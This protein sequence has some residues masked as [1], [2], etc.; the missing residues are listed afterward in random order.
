MTVWDSSPTHR[1]DI[2][3]ALP[4]HLGK[5]LESQTRSLEGGHVGMVELRVRNREFIMIVGIDDDVVARIGDRQLLPNDLS[6]QILRKTV[7]GKPAEQFAY[8]FLKEACTRTSPAWGAIYRQ[9][10]YDF[11]VMQQ[12]PSV[13]AIGRDFGRFL[14][15]LFAVNYFGERY[16]TLFGDRRIAQLKPQVVEPAGS[17]VVVSVASPGNWQAAES[18]YAEVLDTLG[19]EH[20]F[21]RDNDTRMTVAPTFDS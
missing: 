15:G 20:F 19:R 6:L 1:K 9:S 12:T 17:G 10:E 16:V 2:D 11:K 21:D 3:L 13:E 4:G 5:E 7:D 18:S 8:D 14:P